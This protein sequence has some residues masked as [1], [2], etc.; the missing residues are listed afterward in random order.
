MRERERRLYWYARARGGKVRV[1][2][3]SLSL[4]GEG[5]IMERSRA[6]GQRTSHDAAREMDLRRGV[7]A[8]GR[9]WTIKRERNFQSDFCIKRD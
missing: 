3:C 2:S 7:R 5:S 6:R 1:N 8:C 9:A 4:G